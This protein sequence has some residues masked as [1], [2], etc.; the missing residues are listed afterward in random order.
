Q[1]RSSDNL[2]ALD[3]VTS[4]WM[5]PWSMDLMFGL[6]EQDLAHWEKTL[7]KALHFSPTH[8]SAYQ[9]TLTTARS[10]NWGQAG[11]MGL[12]DFFNLTE[13]KLEEAG[14][15]RYEVSNFSK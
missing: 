6:P 14:L 1:A 2:K 3:L 7:D 5:G 9:L 4:E 15:R 10:K 12:L 13:S 11:E 8:I